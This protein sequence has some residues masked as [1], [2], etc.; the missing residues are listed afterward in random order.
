MGELVGAGDTQLLHI[1]RFMLFCLAILGIFYA[2]QIE[3]APSPHGWTWVSVVVGDAFTDIA[4]G[5]IIFVGLIYFYGLEL[6]LKGWLLMTVPV[7]CHL[8]SGLPMIA[9]QLL[10]RRFDNKLS[11]EISATIANR[12]TIKTPEIQDVSHGSPK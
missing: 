12:P 4:M 11:K 3:L 8:T 5:A 1:I 10:K 6:A 7:L 9:G 2:W